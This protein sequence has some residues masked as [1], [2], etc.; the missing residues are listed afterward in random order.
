MEKNLET[1]TCVIIL[2]VIVLVAIWS[3]YIG[4]YRNLLILSISAV[5][6]IYYLL[7]VKQRDD[8][9]D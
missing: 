5:V 7:K 8:D 1:I 2:V 9:S 4:S 3:I 6:N